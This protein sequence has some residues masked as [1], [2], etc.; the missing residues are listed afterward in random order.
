MESRMQIVSVCC[1]SRSKPNG[2]RLDQT[3]KA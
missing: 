2:E 3:D 1:R